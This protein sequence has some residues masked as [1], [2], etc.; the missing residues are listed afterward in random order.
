[1]GY[2][3][4]VS[5]L[6][7]KPWRGFVKGFDEVRLWRCW[8]KM[9]ASISRQCGDGGSIWGRRLTFSLVH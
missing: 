2:V 1:M 4:G 7:K 8:A 6:G 3:C 9:W 5:N